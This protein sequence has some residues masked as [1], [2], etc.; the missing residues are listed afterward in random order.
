VTFAAHEA[1]AGLQIYTIDLVQGSINSAAAGD[2]TLDNSAI[3]A[4]PY[5]FTTVAASGG[6]GGGGGG[7][8]PSITV[9]LPNSG[10]T[11]IG[12]GTYNIT[13]SAPSVTDTVSIYYSLDSGINFPY[14]VATAQT[15][16]GAYTWT[17]PNIGTGTAKIKLVAGSLS[18]ISDG[19]FNITY[20][21]P[22]VSLTNS[23]VAASPTSV[24]ANGTS[25]STITVTVKDAASVPLSGK[26]VSLAS[27]RGSSDTITTVTGTTGADG[28]ATFDVYSSTAGT[29]TYTATAQGTV[30]SNTVSVVFTAVGEPTT[31]AEGETPTSIQVGDLIK[32]S[33]STS[34]YY[35]GSDNKR[36]LFPNEKTYKSWYT[37]WSN[38]KTVTVS[39]LQGIS[40][41]HNATVRPGTV[42]VKIQTDP[43]VY[44][45]EPNGLLRWVPTE[46]RAT[47]LY[48]SAWATKIIDVPLV[49]WVDYSFGSDITTD[50]HPTGTLVQYTG[51]T[52]KY[53]IQGSERRLISTA[54]FTANHFQL[55]HVLSIPTT[56]S[57][58]LGT[59]LTAEET[60]LSRIY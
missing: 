13:W 54:G 21:T 15:N 56:L 10:E 37:D 2:S 55:S 43:K 30:L 7:L 47:T 12:G 46:A 33:L 42:L 6:G 35:Y 9:T 1:W 29:S 4:D 51:T 52:D 23:T 58:T 32:S 40:L 16:D 60:A 28:K 57:Y 44:A 45:V 41:G 26:V 22:T 31:P 3:V 39:Q 59:P 14:T 11:L 24:I 49:F 17:V 38:I 50:A 8:P 20:T 5:T 25:F 53:Y 48:G 19:N 34:V 36:H 27:S 18:D